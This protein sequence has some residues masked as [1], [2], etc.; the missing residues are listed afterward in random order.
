M[1]NRMRS[2]LLWLDS[3]PAGLKLNTELS[4]FYSHGFIGLTAQW[5]SEHHV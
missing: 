1:A 3:W 4:R 2:V 5:T